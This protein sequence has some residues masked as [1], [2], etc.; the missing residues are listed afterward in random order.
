MP[1][2]S[3]KAK[4]KEFLLQN[5]GRKLSGKQIQAAAGDVTEWARRVREIRQ[6]EGWPIVTDKDDSRLR[7]GEYMLTG[8]P[9]KDYTF[10][11]GLSQRVRAEV[12]ER[13]GY[14]C[15]MCGLEAGETDPETGR[16]VVMHI[17]HIVDRA[18]GGAVSPDNLRALCSKCNQGAKHLTQEPPSWT[19]LLG[20]IRRATVADQKKA[21]EWLSN[22]FKH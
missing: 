4:I 21:L 5:I 12:L 1:K 7:P 9:P 3:A 20:Q 11:P 6:D 13:N 8:K 16:R 17:G 10:E 22:K 15:R 19:W 18:H 14:T 2:L